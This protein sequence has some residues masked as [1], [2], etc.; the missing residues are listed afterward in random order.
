MLSYTREWKYPNGKT[1]TRN[2]HPDAARKYT[3][4]GSPKDTPLLVFDDDGLSP[5]CITEGE[6]DAQS[7]S[8]AM[9][10]NLDADLVCG[11]SYPSGWKS[12]GLADYG[13]VK[14]RPVVI[15]PD[16]DDGL[17]ALEVVSNACQLAGATS[18]SVVPDN[19][20]GAADIPPSEIFAV[21]ASTEPHVSQTARPHACPTVR[22]SRAGLHRPRSTG[23]RNGDDPRC[24][25]EIGQVTVDH[26]A[27]VRELH[28]RFMA[29]TADSPYPGVCIS[30]RRLAERSIDG[31]PMLGYPPTYPPTDFS[32][33]RYPHWPTWRRGSTSSIISVTT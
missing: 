21:L 23:K 8:D 11:S 28:R 14:G 16:F 19:T 33:I 17:A 1:V 12:A 13:V 10:V 18:I 25:T 30:V 5:I 7:V 9:Y 15:W 20:K 3:S 31:L 4:P 24:Q 27:T 22:A 29:R 2:D 32:I 6:Q 26:V